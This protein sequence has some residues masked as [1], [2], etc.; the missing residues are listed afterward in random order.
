MNRLLELYLLS[1]SFICAVVLII[2]AFVV[3]PDIIRVF[4]PENSNNYNDI[5]YSSNADY[6]NDFLSKD[7]TKAFSEYK[8]EDLNKQ[9][10]QA[11]ERELD[12]IRLSAKKSIIVITPAVLFTILLGVLHFSYYLSCKRKD[13]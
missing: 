8:E 11:K 1:V 3:G 4:Y 6:Y 2:A 13:I 12:K 10:L 5:A 7:S 9:R